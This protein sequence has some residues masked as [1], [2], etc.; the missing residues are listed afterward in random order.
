MEWKFGEDRI[1]FSAACNFIL[2]FECAAV[3]NYNPY[4]PIMEGINQAHDN[5]ARW[6][7][8]KALLQLSKLQYKFR[9]CVEVELAF[10]VAEDMDRPILC[11]AALWENIGFLG[12][13]LKELPISKSAATYL[14]LHCFSVKDPI[15]DLT[16]M[17]A[18]KDCSSRLIQH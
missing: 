16:I 8:T 14:S 2:S 7:I 4:H 5:T 6:H 1:A 13:F 10:S 12:D 3:H 11:L 18:S 15:R 9:K 17:R